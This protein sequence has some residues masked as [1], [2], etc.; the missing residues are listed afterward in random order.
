ELTTIYGVFQLLTPLHPLTPMIII[1]VITTI[2]TAFGGV[3][4]SLMTD[5]IQCVLIFVL[6]IIAVITVGV[7]V[8]PSKEDI[9]RA[10]LVKPTKMGGELFVILTLAIAFSDMY[11]QGFWQR[12][13][14]SRNDHDLRWATFFGFWLVFVVTALVGMAGP[15]AAWAGTWSPD[16][17]VP[18]SSAFFTIIA[19]MPGWVSGLTL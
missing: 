3:F 12:T 16:S 17:D 1:C 9:E 5:A 7:S 15:L 8:R 11:H 6:I 4:A 14:A 19:S 18:G 2:Y 13:F 10:G